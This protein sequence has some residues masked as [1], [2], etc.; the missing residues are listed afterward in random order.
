MLSR[1]TQLAGTKTEIAWSTMLAYDLD[2]RTCALNDCSLY[3]KTLATALKTL[4]TTKSCEA[5]V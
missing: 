1:E 3:G 5:K 4:A 2:L